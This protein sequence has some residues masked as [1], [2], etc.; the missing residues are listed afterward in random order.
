MSEGSKRRRRRPSSPVLAAPLPDNDDILREI[1]LRLPP[2]PSSLPRA[3]LVSKRWRR[4]LSDP[5]FLRRFRAFH[6]RRAPL[7]GFYI[8]DFGIPYFTPT[9]DPPD[10]I[11][12]A[13]LSLALPR[14]ERRSL[15]FLGCRH[16]LVLIL[17]RARLEITVW[18]P[19]AGDQRCVTLPPG[20]NSQD[21]RLAVRGG[22]LL[23]DDHAGGRAPLESFKVV[24][25]RTD[26]VLL[27]ADPHAFA[28][29][30]ESN[31]GVWSNIISTSIRAP[32]W[33]LKPSILVGNSLYWLLLGYGNSGI[34]KFD[35]DRNNLTAFDTPPVAQAQVSSQS[36]ILRMEDSRLGFAIVTGF[37]IQVWEK[38]PNSEGGAKWMLH[39][40]I[41]LD[42]LLSLGPMGDRSRIVIHGYDEDGI[43]IFVSAD[44]QVFMIKL[45]SLQ[46]KSLFKCGIIDTYH[47]FTSFYTT[48][49]GIG[50]G[51]TGA[52]ILNNT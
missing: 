31:A 25:L 52:D 35:L 40:T 46:F 43:A 18:D 21:P 37:S 11:P 41:N 33:L 13:R 6:H 38:R 3:S 20:F 19:V 15:S 24:V 45:K 39:K 7:L 36:Q 30:Y 9:L 10:R 50:S 26:D 16:G 28:F 8:G 17:N 2:L 12:S 51:D 48:G 27:D 29:L 14:D 32:L 1:L 44:L 49:R 5:Q 42:K 47:P 22:A 4:I 23:C 34:L